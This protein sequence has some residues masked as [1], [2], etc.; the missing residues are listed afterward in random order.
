MA[1]CVLVRKAVEADAE[2]I[3]QFNTAMARET[4][5]RELEQ[6]K[7]GPGIKALLAHP[8]Y[9]FYLV[10][11]MEGHVVGSLMITTEWS[12]WNNGLYWWV[13]SVYVRT[14]FRRRGIYRTLY[15]DVRARASDNPAVCGCRLYV[16]RDNVGAQQAYTRLG[17]TETHYKIFEEMMDR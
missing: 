3:A 4:E 8:E 2:T 9:G 10:A 17:M 15:E 5:G 1:D 7:T 6:A 16:E 11:E 12:D 14:E 13:Q